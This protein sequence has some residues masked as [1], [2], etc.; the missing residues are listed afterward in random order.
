[1]A[2]LVVYKI[3]NLINGLIYIGSASN[4]KERWKYH[5]WQLNKGIHGNK[6]LQNAWKLYGKEAFAIVILAQASDKENLKILEQQIIDETK[7]YERNIGYNI[8]KSVT[9][10]RLGLKSSPEHV[11][12]IIKAHTGA[13]RSEEACKNIGLAKKGIELTEERKQARRNY[14][15][16]LE[17]IIKIKAASIGRKHTEEAK[18]KMSEKARARATAKQ[19]ELFEGMKIWQ[20]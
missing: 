18:L 6:H 12:K 4:I 7:C 15:H 13:K 20:G 19:D 14:R 1:M 5:K 11:A 10:S 16:T 2:G 9:I 8:C 3:V 17:A